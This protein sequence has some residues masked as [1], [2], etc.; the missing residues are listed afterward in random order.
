MS[1]QLTIITNAVLSIVLYTLILWKEKEYIFQLI[2][3]L[4]V[5]P[6]T[7]L[8][9]FFIIA[10]FT[11][12]VEVIIAFILISLLVFTNLVNKSK[13]EKLSPVESF[14]KY[15]ISKLFIGI[16]FV[17]AARVVCELLDSMYGILICL[18][19]YIILDK[20][21]FGKTKIKMENKKI[22]LNITGN[23]II[24]IGVG[25]LFIIIII[26][27]IGIIK[28]NFSKSTI[29]S[30]IVMDYSE[31]HEIYTDEATIKGDYFSGSA[32]SML[33]FAEAGARKTDKPKKND[34][35]DTYENIDYQEENN[36]NITEIEKTEENVENVRNIFLE[37]LAFIPELI[38]ENGKVN[39]SLPISDN[40]TTWNIQTVGNTKNGNVGSSSKTFKVFKEFFVDYSL[41]TNSVVTDKV[42][43][44]VTLYNYT[45][46][47]LNIDVNVKDNEWSKVGEYQK[48]VKVPAN[49]TSMIYVPIEIIKSGDNTLRIETKAGNVSD[50]VEKNIS[51][52]EKGIQVEEVVSTGSME[53]NLTQDIIYSEN[54]VENTKNLKVKLYSSS[55]TQVID[56][57]EN[58][59][60]LPTGCF[61]QT[62]SSLY[63]DVL[64]LKYLQQNNLDNEQVREK[65]LS[66]ISSGYQRLLTFEVEGTKGG[67]S[68]YGRSPAEP[69][70]TAFGLMELNELSQVYKVDENV[71][72]NM[73]DYLFKVQKINGTFDYRS[74]YIGSASSTDELAMNSY[75]IWAL[76]ETCPNEPRLTKSVEYLKNKI[77]DATDNY[78][79]ALMANIFENVNDTASSKKVINKLMKSVILNDDGTASVSSKIRDYYG[80]SGRYQDIQTSALFSIA[81]SKNNSNE[82]TN[83]AL[84]NFLLAE[85]SYNSTWGTTQ[86][87]VLAL[88][89]INDFEGNSQVDNQTITVKMN[90]DAKSVDIDKNSLDIY[91]FDFKNLSE[92]NKLSIEMKKGR[93]YYEV[94]KKYYQSYDEVKNRVTPKILV[95]Q[96][97]TQ[98]AKVNDII[99]QNIKVVNN[100]DNSIT[101]GLVQINI[102]QGTSVN[103][104]SLM[105]LVHNG[106]VEKY[107]YNYGKINLYLK[108]FTDKK[109]LNLEIKY[110]ALYPETVTV[111]AIRTYDYYNPE[112]EGICAPV[113]IIVNK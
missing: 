3:N 84:I 49:S 67:Y 74:T 12:S 85:K 20:Y 52:S 58:I 47:E 56:N 95:D 113:Q 60:K 46:T 54:T 93:F 10:T 8:L 53:H 98:V 18:V 103:E 81:L 108:N 38:T 59:L 7:Y 16:I 33:N 72:N 30:D 78:T 22:V 83:Q 26:V 11:E 6:T 87:T 5:I 21:I 90:D 70:I 82:K 111:G 104:D 41:P 89:A 68:L 62:S 92:E 73:K 42:E 80:T 27:G 1:M 25:I 97:I 50:I 75:I 28:D 86:N 2:L 69:V 43:I 57:I 65:A 36:P 31:V 48:Q 14:F 15:T 4:I 77:D 17:I 51:V 106:L 101:N 37:S 34:I 29:Q 110:R 40:I 13:K 100:S 99:T 45:E 9:I 44:P 61:E 39:L 91:E 109:E 94:I 32:N 35:K 64:V 88:K 79:L 105:L 112:V 19:V 71:L 107:E 63:P 66:Y 55:M 76:S 102:P 23:D 96:T 24:V